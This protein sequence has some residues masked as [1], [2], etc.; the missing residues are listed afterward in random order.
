MRGI[1][2]TRR[3]KELSASHGLVVIED[4]CHALGAEHKGRAPAVLADM[5]SQLHPVKHL[6]T[7]EGG[8]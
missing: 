4:A 8:M 3:V 1:R 2:Q 7:G 6:A 5:T